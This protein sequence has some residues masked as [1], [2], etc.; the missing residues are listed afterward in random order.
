MG[1]TCEKSMCMDAKTEGFLAEKCNEIRWSVVLVVLFLFFILP[2][3]M[4][5][6]PNGGQWK[7]NFGDF[8]YVLK[9]NKKKV[10]FNLFLQLKTLF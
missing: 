10:L 4:I 8:N 6:H 2:L 7:Y 3:T 5:E 1:G 9:P